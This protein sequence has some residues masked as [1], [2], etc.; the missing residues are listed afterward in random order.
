MDEDSDIT[1]ADHSFREHQCNS[2]IQRRRSGPELF[3]VQ[4][5]KGHKSGKI[6]V[7]SLFFRSD[8]YSLQTVKLQIVGDWSCIVRHS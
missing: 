1:P 3:E 7:Q 8:S 4:Y 6:K 5:R 2:F